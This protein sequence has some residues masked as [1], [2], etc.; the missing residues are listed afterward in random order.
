MKK[1]TL[2][3]NLKCTHYIFFAIYKLIIYFKFF[4]F[5]FFSP[6]QMHQFKVDTKS[7]SMFN[8]IILNTL[9]TFYIYSILHIIIIF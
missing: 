8:R 9:S 3:M 2:L 5:F 4:I 1:D 6:Q 7:A